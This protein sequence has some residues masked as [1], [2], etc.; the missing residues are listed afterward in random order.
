[1]CGVVAGDVA[2]PVAAGRRALD[3]VLAVL[4]AG[5]CGERHVARSASGTETCSQIHLG[6][7]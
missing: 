6:V 5:S 7:C 4:A 2:D 1:M 3:Q